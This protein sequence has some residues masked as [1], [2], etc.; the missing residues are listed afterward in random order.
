MATMFG[1][2]GI[3]AALVVAGVGMATAGV[4]ASGVAHAGEAQ[5]TSAA[6]G[7]CPGVVA[8]LARGSEENDVYPPTAANGWSNGYEGDTLHRFLDYTTQI[9]PD[10]FGERDGGHAQV[11]AVDAERYP[12]KF[13]VGEAGEDVD[14]LTVVTGVGEFVDSMALGLPGGIETV[15]EYETSTGC[16]PDY[17]ALGYSQGVAVLGP[18]QQQLAEQGRLR[19]AVYMGNPFHRTPELIT[20]G[21]FRAHSYCVPDD[22]VCDFGPRSAFL[23]LTDEDDAGVHAG[24]FSA[25]AGDPSR[26]SAGDRRAADAF[27]A[28]VRDPG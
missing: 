16:A 17:V 13:P 12:A 1:V 5:P 4:A 23:A 20:G 22:F 3:A 27:A 28:L 14:P 11:L 10:L 15:E 6:S 2:K 7:T 26:A 9:H 8:L 25:A 18:V 21:A 19:G 24:Y